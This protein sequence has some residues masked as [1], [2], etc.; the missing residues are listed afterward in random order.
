MPSVSGALGSAISL[1]QLV[2]VNAAAQIAPRVRICLFIV[3]VSLKLEIKSE[4]F[5]FP[6]INAECAFTSLTNRSVGVEL[7][8]LAC[9]SGIVCFSV[10]FKI[11]MNHVIKVIINV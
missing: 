4:V 7:N 3:S 1:L 10:H 2:R 8:G 9:R 5:V 11:R 6:R